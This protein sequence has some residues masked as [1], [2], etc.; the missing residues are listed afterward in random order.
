MMDTGVDIPEVVN[1]VFFKKLMSKIKFWQMIGRGTRLCQNLNVISPKKA[2]FERQINDN[3]REYYN[4]K[5][6]FLI[7]DVCNVFK[8]FNLNPDGKKVIHKHYL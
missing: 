8:F 1:L 3:S 7:F 2:Y 4:D 5:Q 6:G